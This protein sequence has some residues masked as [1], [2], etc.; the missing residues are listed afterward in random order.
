VIKMLV[1][2]LVAG[3]G[4]GR[5]YQRDAW[6]TIRHWPYTGLHDLVMY[7]NDRYPD[8]TNNKKA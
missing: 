4:Y 1:Y 6:E 8:L 3:R 5:W 7:L 2:D